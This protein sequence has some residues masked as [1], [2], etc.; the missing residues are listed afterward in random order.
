MAKQGTF[1]GELQRGWHRFWRLSWWWKGPFLGIVA[2]FVL[3]GIAS[4][5]GG[6]SE[7]KSALSATEEATERA[8]QKPVAT[9]TKRATAEPTERATER[10]TAA[11]TPAPTVVVVVTRG[12]ANS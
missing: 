3:G 2:I 6:G 5:A 7:D 9:A 11:P 12:G 1:L 8:T 4:A 10:V